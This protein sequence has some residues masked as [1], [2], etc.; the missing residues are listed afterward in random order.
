MHELS[1]F[2]AVPGAERTSAKILRPAA[3]KAGDPLRIAILRRSFLSRCHYRTFGCSF[4]STPSLLAG[5]SLQ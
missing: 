3:W 1:G 5:R 4:F 2:V